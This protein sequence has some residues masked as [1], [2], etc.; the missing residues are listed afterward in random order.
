[1]TGK[2]FVTGKRRDWETLGN[3][4]PSHD[5][6]PHGTGSLSVTSEYLVLGDGS[7]GFPQTSTYFVVLGNIF[8]RV[9]I[10]S[11]T[12]LSLSVAGLPKPFN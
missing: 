1:M 12:R 7:P 2:H 6:I 10:F 11:L 4:F 9:I 5:T 3:L 8:G